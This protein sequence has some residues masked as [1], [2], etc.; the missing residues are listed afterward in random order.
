[1]SGEAPIP[2]IDPSA[3]ALCYAEAAQAYPE[4]ACG[5]LI[6]PADSDAC[7]EA[8]PCKNMQNEL[9]LKDPETYPRDASRGYNFGIRDL[10]YLE[11]SQKSR[12]PAKIIYHS[13]CDVGAYFSEEDQ[14]AATYEGELLYPVDYLVID[15]AAAGVRGAKLFRFRDGQFVEVASYPAAS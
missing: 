10:R 2:R 7:D 8:R 4:E 12:R 3:L 11:D 9:H 15:C 14:R 13:H 1:M 6:G 5:L